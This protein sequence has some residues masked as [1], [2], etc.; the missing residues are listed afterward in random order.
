MKRLFLFLLVSGLLLCAA[1][2]PKGGGVIFEEKPEAKLFQSAGS[3]FE[4]RNYNQAF[5]LYQDYVQKYPDA[6]RLPDALLKM[7]IIR[8]RQG[9]AAPAFAYLEQVISNYPQ[10]QNARQASVERLSLLYD[11]GNFRKVIL[12]AADVFAYRLSDEQFVRVGLLAGDAYMALNMAETAYHGFLRTYQRAGRKSREEAVLPRVKAAINLFSQERI[13]DELA[14][15]DGRFP[16]SWLLYRLGVNF[17][18]DGNFGE[19]IAALTDFL[20]RYSGHELAETARERI[21]A[22]KSAGYSQQIIIGCLLPLSGKY[23]AFGQRALNGIELAIFT[24]DE[25]AGASAP[26]VQLMVA[27]TCSSPENAV[28]A[29]RELDEKRVTVII[30]PLTNTQNAAEEAQSRGIPIVTLSQAAGVPEIGEYVFRNF[31]TAGMQV[32]TLAAYAAETLDIDRFAMLYPDEPYG[33]T[34]MN[35]FWDALLARDAAVV[36]LEKY[37]PEHTDFSDAIKKLVGLYYEVPEDIADDRQLGPVIRQRSPFGELWG[38]NRPAA[39][40]TPLL[41]SLIDNAPVAPEEEPEP[42]VDFG[43]LFIPDSPEKAGLILPQLA[44]YD[45]TNVYCLGTNLWHSKRLIQ[46]ARRYLQGAVFPSGFFAGSQAGPVQPFVRQFNSLYG[47]QPEFIEAVSFDSAR[48]VVDLMR[49]SKYLG[50]RYIRRQLT[51]MPPHEGVTGR[52]WFDASGEAVKELYLL[53]VSG[54]RFVEVNAGN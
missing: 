25:A 35:L 32:K 29:V 39:E 48:M 18:A 34:F 42:I 37:D 8:A 24:G 49:R 52:T 47:T 50:R 51:L 16:S 7:G 46:M 45:V 21:E 10:S 44:Y 20:D 22:L 54:N 15:L 40:L 27:D 26:P 12:A 1:C 4:A 28:E 41:D 17:E 33:D 5:S 31:I 43:A 11:T 53:K 23:E 13:Q 14:R 38:L 36:G 30:G 2:A 19:A 6:P 3:A 9:Q